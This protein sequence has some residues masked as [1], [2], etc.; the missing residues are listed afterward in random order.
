M[1]ASLHRMASSRVLDR[2]ACVSY[3]LTKCRTHLHPHNCPHCK[4]RRLH[5]FQSQL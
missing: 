1:S 5:F 4:V 2:R 3:A